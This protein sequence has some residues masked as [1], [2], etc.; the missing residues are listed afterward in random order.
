[1]SSTLSDQT[2]VEYEFWEHQ[3]DV[4]GRETRRARARAGARGDPPLPPRPAFVVGDDSTPLGRLV[5]RARDFRGDARFGVVVLILVAVVAGFVWY[6]IGVGGGDDAAA[7]PTR[8]SAPVATRASASATSRASGTA[9]GAPAAGAKIVV[10]VAGAVVHAGVV[11]LPANARVID[12]I[13]AVGG[14][15]ADGDLDRLNL[16]AKVSD[17]ERVFVAKVG[18]ADPGVLGEPTGPSGSASSGGATGGAAGVK[19]NLN[20]ATQAQ[21]EALPGIGPSYA[22]AIIA[23]RQARAGF[24]SVNELRNV[25]G[26]GDKRFEQLAPLVTV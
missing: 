1:M 20:T 4:S 24:K 22:Q 21:L 8:R 5:E 2:D 23:E 12:A 16:A 26:I 14:A 11:E 9:A 15:Q 18:Q 25:R 17:G 6:R 13:E 3:A 7:A 19:V 10:H